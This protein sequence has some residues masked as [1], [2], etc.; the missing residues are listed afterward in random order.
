MRT[1]KIIL[2]VL[3][4]ALMVAFPSYIFAAEVTRTTVT[5]TVDTVRPGDTIRTYEVINTANASAVQA[6]VSPG[7][8]TLVMRGMPIRVVPSSR[9]DWPPPYVVATEKYSPQC[10]LYSDGSL[11]GYVAGLPFPLL[12]PNDPWIAS[13]IIWNY[14]YRPMYSDDVDIRYPE[15]ATY[16]P[17]NDERPVTYLSAGH[18]A[19]YNNVGRVEVPPIPTD[20]D[21]L[22]SGIRWKFA[23]FPFMEP[24]AMNGYGMLRFRYMD[25]GRADDI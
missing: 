9:L 11:Q 21:A 14:T 3:T 7:N 4:I 24:S 10:R 2:P 23:M 16:A 17:W 1:A 22:Q 5:T 18:M 19:L 12:D 15:I 25:P 20:P 8:Y 13:K 6:Y